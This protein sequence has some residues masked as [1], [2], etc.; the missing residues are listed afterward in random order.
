MRTQ[1]YIAAGLLLLT[2]GLFAQNI[3][4][5]NDGSKYAYGENIG[6]LNF[7]PALVDGVTVGDS[8]VT[9]FVWCEYIGWINLFP[10]VDGAASSTT[11]SVNCQ[12]SPGAK[13]SAGSILTRLRPAKSMTSTAFASTMTAILKAGPGARISA[14]FISPQ[15]RRW[16]TK[17]QPRG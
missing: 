1:S 17:S 3:D 6:W 4:P 14:G 2:S 16:R 9:G 11:A 12:A 5:L 7:K 10:A 8:I 13:T 15:S